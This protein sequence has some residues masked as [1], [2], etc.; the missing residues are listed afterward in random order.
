[1]SGAPVLPGAPLRK[2]PFVGRGALPFSDVAIVDVYELVSGAID[3]GARRLR[4][5]DSVS[6]WSG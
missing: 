1:M 6:E 4:V 2:P 5:E 3:E